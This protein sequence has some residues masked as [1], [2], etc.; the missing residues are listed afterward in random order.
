MDQRPITLTVLEL[1]IAFRPGTDMERVKTAARMIEDLYAE[2]K[3][4][5]RGSQSKDV[6][7]T[8]LALGLADE[9]LQMKTQQGLERERLQALIAKIEKSQ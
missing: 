7:L 1:E 8:F 6:V 9:L 5:S 2:Q 4:K 3:L